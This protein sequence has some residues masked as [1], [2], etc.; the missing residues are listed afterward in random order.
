MLKFLAVAG[1][2]AAAIRSEA[3]EQKAFATGLASLNAI[4]QGGWPVGEIV[5]LA[6]AKGT[7][8][9]A[10]L[11]SSLLVLV[12]ISSLVAGSQQCP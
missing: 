2:N 6:G 5:E 9:T 10:R 8:K 11:A 1:Q 12:L 3:A 7:G 4:L